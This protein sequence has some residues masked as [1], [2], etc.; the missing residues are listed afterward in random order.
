MELCVSVNENYQLDNDVVLW[1]QVEEYTT[2]SDDQRLRYERDKGRDSEI[3]NDEEIDEKRRE[4]SMD[5]EPNTSTCSK[6]DI[7]TRP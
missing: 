3:E 7:E 6:L 4:G 2:L 1:L 5:C